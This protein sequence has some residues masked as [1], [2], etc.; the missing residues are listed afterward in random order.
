[1]ARW[2]C[3]VGAGFAAAALPALLVTYLFV[4]GCGPG[5]HGLV[6]ALKAGKV[7]VNVAWCSGN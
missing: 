5:H 1:M 2:L 3:T 7:A 4:G 6:I